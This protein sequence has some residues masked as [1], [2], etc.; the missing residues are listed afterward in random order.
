MIRRISALGFSLSLI[1]AGC[2]RPAPEYAA[3]VSQEDRDFGAQQHPQLLA[4]FGGEYRG[5][6]EDYVQ[7][8]GAT[9]SDAAGLGGRCTF[10]LVNSDVVNAFAV[11]GCYIYVTR[12]LMA[13][14]SSEAE[15]A[16]VLGHEVGHIVARHSQRQ[17]S[18]SLWSMLG[19]IVVSLT[20]SERL[21]RLAG[22]AAEMFTL[23]YSRS[24]EY[25]ADELGIRFLRRAGYDPYAAA[26]M[27]DALGRQEA[28][29]TDSGGRDAARGVPEWALSHPLTGKRVERAHHLAE[30]TGL[31]DDALSEN[32]PAY[33]AAVDGL[34]YGDDPEQGFV[35]GRRFAHPIMRIGFEAPEGFTLT[36]SPQAITLSGPAGVRGEF[37]GGPI[38]PGGLPAYVEAMLPQLLGDVQAEIGIAQATIVNGLPTIIVPV[39]ILTREGSLP[40]AVAAYDA[41]G[42]HAYHFAIVSPPSDESAA[43]IQRLFASF[44]LLAPEEVAR[45]RPRVVRVV[46]VVPGETVQSLARRVADPHGLALLTALNGPGAVRPGARVK[47]VTLA[48]KGSAGS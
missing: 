20:G 29:L 2:D 31:M 5:P 7:R 8:L 37:A 43:A 19:V 22:A 9:V 32:A 4:Q 41:G 13:I 16:S 48:G 11:P 35:L 6:Q 33:L 18:R 46:T 42:G 38:P 15:L 3:S 12:G 17:Q 10:T 14:V 40:L 21:T 44:H 23:R 1:L 27:L 36:N 45:L 28:F 34:L 24:Q 30:E 39:R 47:I 25:E 26:D